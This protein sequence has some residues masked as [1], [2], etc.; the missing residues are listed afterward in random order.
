M[1]DELQT[2]L[3][4]YEQQLLDPSVRREPATASALLAEDFREFGSSGRSF[5]RSAIL[6]LL[7]SEPPSTQPVATI[8]DFALTRFGAD[9]A[10]V[11]YRATHPTRITLRSS[12]WVCREGRWLLLFHQGTLAG[13]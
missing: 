5:D 1:P 13:R 6:D 12:L 3:L 9:A 7:A 2:L 11:T 4:A 10:L 8:S